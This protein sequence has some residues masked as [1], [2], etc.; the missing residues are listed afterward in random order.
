MTIDGF[1]AAPQFKRAWQLPI[2]TNALVL[3]LSHIIEPGG[4]VS[5]SALVDSAVTPASTFFCAQRL[6]G[7]AL[8]GDQL[9]GR[10]IHL[11]IGSWISPTFFMCMCC[12]TTEPISATMPGM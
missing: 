9:A 1:R 3:Y 8:L 6:T 11:R 12:P 10:L 5:V 7:R 4:K 2:S